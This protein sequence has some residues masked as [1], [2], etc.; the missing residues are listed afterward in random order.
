MQPLGPLAP[1]DGF[2]NGLENGFD[3]MPQAASGSRIVLPRLLRRP[4]RHFLRLLTG[5]IRFSK[6]GLAVSALAAVAVSAAILVYQSGHGRLIVNNVS[7]SLGITVSRYEVSGN[8]ETPDSDVV[9]LIAATPGHAILEYD[10]DAARKTLKKHPWISD[11]VISRVYP[12]TISIE[13]TE[14]PP[15]A[16]WQAPEGVKIIG[17]NGR[18][19][20]DYDG[21]PRGLP[22]VVG[23][24]AEREAA[25]MLELMQRYPGISSETKAL[26]RVGERR[27]DL[28]LA[29]GITVMLPEKDEATELERLSRMASEQ[30]LFERDVEMIDMR[31][32]DRMVVRM[33]SEGGE[34]VR[35]RREEQLKRL[36][37][38]QK[39]RNT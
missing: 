37:D 22:L 25:R 28:E 12:D 1:N 24:G 16:L 39:E 8:V 4:V 3:G 29:S 15:M 5:G 35:A 33:S 9:G 32:P 7:Q 31:M 38:A 17:E 11:A 6:R 27:W 19:L 23:K 18:I 34:L 14:Y 2:G 21:N 10:V 30:G 20:A 36:A 26:V 13:I